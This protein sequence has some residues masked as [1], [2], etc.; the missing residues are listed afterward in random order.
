M[1]GF[2]QKVSRDKGNP[3]DESRHHGARDD[4]CDEKGILLLCHQ[5]MRNPYRDEMVP[6]VNP[7]DIKSV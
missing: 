2:W 1:L 7:V 6:N 4:G 5:P 3:R